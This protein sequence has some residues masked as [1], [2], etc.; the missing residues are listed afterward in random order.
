MDHRLL[1]HY[2]GDVTLANV[3]TGRGR[4]SRPL[5]DPGAAS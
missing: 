5:T 2:G 3:K 4:G 1:E